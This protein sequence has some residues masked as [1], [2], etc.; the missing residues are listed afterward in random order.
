MFSANQITLAAQHLIAIGQTGTSD[1]PDTRLPEHLRPQNNRQALDIQREVMRLRGGKIGAWKC[2]LPTQG[3]IIV[4]RILDYDIV[5]CGPRCTL[6]AI[7]GMASVEPEIAFVIGTDLP[8]RPIPYSRDEVTQAIANTHLAFELIAT[9]YAEPDLLTFPEALADGLSNSGLLL[10]PA[11]YWKDQQEL[12]GIALT[13]TGPDGELGR[14]EGRH[15]DGDPLLPLYWLANFLAS[16]G[17]GLKSGQIVITGS[18]HGVIRIPQN[19]LLE[20]RYG[21]LGTLIIEVNEPL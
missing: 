11:I 6:K 19:V 13:L 12:A 2:A 14:W 9:R 20:M 21:D 15:P 5:Q 17:S 3:K 16:Q 18:Y 4:A 10:G 1:I 7:N 8:P